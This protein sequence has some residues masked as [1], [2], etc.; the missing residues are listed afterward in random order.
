MPGEISPELAR[1]LRKEKVQYMPAYVP[2]TNYVVSKSYSS[3]HPGV[4]MVAPLGTPVMATADG[5][6]KETGEDS[7]YG[8]YVLLGHGKDYTS[9]YG[10]LSRIAI[11]QGEQV[12]KGTIIGYLGATGQASAPHLHFELTYKDKKDDPAKILRLKP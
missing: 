7:I 9:F 5:I 4:D 3:T 11:T 12:T 10:H 6:V 8:K 1:Q 2:L